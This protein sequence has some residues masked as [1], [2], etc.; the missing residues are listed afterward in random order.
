MVCLGGQGSNLEGPGKRTFGQ[1]P[2][3][4]R[5]RLKK[6][7]EKGWAV[8]AELKQEQSWPREDLLGV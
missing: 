7:R 3:G 6:V 5:Q 4:A 2:E 8:Q 1:N